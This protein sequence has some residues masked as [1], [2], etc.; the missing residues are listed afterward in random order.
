MR[1][2]VATRPN[3]STIGSALADACS[4]AAQLVGRVHVEERTAL[5]VERFPLRL[6]THRTRS[7]SSAPFSDRSPDGDRRQQR[8]DRAVAVGRVKR[9]R[10]GGDRHDRIDVRV[11]QIA[12]VGQESD[13]EERHVTRDDDVLGPGRSEPGH[14]RRSGP[15]YGRSS[16]TTRAGR[17]RRRHWPAPPPRPGRHTRSR[18]RGRSCGAAEAGGPCRSHPARTAARQDD[19]AERYGFEAR[20]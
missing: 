20:P 18:S 14:E 7:R 5:G 19:P 4:S 9:L 11:Q 17:A 2:S 16:S 8:L 10:A 12:E 3:R 1:R 15:S 6:R 13:V